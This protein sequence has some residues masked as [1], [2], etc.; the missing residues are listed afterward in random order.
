MSDTCRL[1]PLFRD[2][3]L[4]CLLPSH[5]FWC[6]S[7]ERWTLHPPTP[8]PFWPQ[9]II[10]LF[11]SSFRFFPCSLITFFS[12]RLCYHLS[13]FCVSI[14]SFWFVVIL[15]VMY[16]CAKIYLIFPGDSDSKETSCNVGDL[17]LI[18]GLWRSP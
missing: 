9:P 1:F 6:I 13:S 15:E 18:P 16:T 2:P 14:A 4:S 17:G 5:Y 8:L 11:S 7:G 12:V 10:I 3:W